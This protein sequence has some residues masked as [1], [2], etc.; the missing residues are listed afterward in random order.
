MVIYHAIYKFAYAPICNLNVKVCVFY[1]NL[2]IIDYCFRNLKIFVKR[3]LIPSLLLL[4][5]TG[6]HVIA[7]FDSKFIYFLMIKT[8]LSAIELKT[9]WY[10]VGKAV[11]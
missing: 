9:F 3:Y 11:R 10:V 7:E 8:L 2:S 5:R 4:L 1:S 6:I